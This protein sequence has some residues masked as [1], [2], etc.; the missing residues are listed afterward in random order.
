MNI[1]TFPHSL[2]TV[3]KTRFLYDELDKLIIEHPNPARLNS[4]Q[5]AKAW[6]TITLTKLNCWFFD[7]GKNFYMYHKETFKTVSEAQAFIDR[8]YK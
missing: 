6:L 8:T 3:E 4:R 1:E 5:Y 7:D 2:E